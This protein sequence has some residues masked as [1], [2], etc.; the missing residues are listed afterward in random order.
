LHLRGG[1][2]RIRLRKNMERQL[3]EGKGG[4]TIK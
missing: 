1:G 2:R 4:E 3:K